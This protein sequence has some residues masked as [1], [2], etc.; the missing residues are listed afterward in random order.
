LAADAAVAKSS[1]RSHDS[2]A[3]GPASKTRQSP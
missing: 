2:S 3:S 1:K